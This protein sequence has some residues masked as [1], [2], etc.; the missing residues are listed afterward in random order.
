MPSSPFEICFRHVEQCNECDYAARR[1]CLTGRL[2]FNAALDAC[3][4][5]AGAVDVKAKASA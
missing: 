3:K 2:L 1:L 5:I 4:L